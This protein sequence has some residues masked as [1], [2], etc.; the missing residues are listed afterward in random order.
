VQKT[1][2][3]AGKS[4]RENSTLVTVFVSLISVMYKCNQNSVLKLTGVGFSSES[5]SLFCITSLEQSC[6]RNVMFV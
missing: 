3:S 4:K 2:L 1:V 6:T 5:C